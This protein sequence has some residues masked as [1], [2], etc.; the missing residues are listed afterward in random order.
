MLLSDY[1]ALHNK[2][3]ADISRQLNLSASAVSQWQEIPGKWLNVL[4]G[5]W[6]IHKGQLYWQGGVFGHG[7]EWDYSYSPAK[8]YHIRR[9]L[10][11]MGS[12]A[13]VADWVKPV[14]FDRSFIQAVKDNAVCP[15]VV[16]MVDASIDGGKRI[17]SR[18]YP[19]EAAAA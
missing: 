5:G 13:A 16:D 10:N 4:K 11:Q 1:L 2:T 7:S 18:V 3:K 12:V 9:L 15:I 8:I 14:Q 6:T 19:F 17:P